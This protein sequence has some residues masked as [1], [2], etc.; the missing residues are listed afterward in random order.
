MSVTIS[1]PDEL[2]HELDRLAETQQQERTAYALDVLWRDVL[3]HKQ[4]NALRSS[5]GAWRQ[6]DHPDLDSGGAAYVERIRSEG[7]ERFEE[8]IQRKNR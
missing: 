3:R 6:E 8:A 1:L 7:D 5:A 4:A 2:A